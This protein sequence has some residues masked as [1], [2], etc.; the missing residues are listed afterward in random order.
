MALEGALRDLGLAEVLQLLASGQRTGVLRVA[1][2]AGSRVALLRFHEGAIVAG[3]WDDE[4]D[5]LLAALLACGLCTQD[6][7]VRAADW[8]LAQLPTGHVVDGLVETG[9]VG[10]RARDAVARRLVD[11]LCFELTTVDDGSWSFTDDETAAVREPAT[12]L[13]IPGEALVLD[14]ARRRDEWPQVVAVI[15]SL[16]AVPVIAAVQ[17]TSPL[18]EPAEGWQLLAAVDGVRTVR[19]V[20]SSAGLRVFEAARWVARWVQLDVLTVALP[21]ADADEARARYLGRAP[22]VPDDGRAHS[23]PAFVVPSHD[24]LPIHASA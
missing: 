13:R 10:A 15:G 2:G 17:G 19:Q 8:A 16:A 24:L 5:A 3:R 22:A 1:G 12:S 9:A 7:L 21:A 11:D 18:T 20:A 14:A 23:A 6:D 4:P